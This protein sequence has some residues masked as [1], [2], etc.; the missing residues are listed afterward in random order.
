M[1]KLIISL[2]ELIL[3]N[4]SE[5]LSQVFSIF[6]KVKT[7]I[8][9]PRYVRDHIQIALNAL[10]EHGLSL[11]GLIEDAMVLDENEELDLIVDCLAVADE[12]VVHKVAWRIVQHYA[13]DRVNQS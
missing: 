4:V 11:D 10:V 1:S 12:R 13:F 5:F 3:L 6:E 9:D 2:S 8:D 7:V